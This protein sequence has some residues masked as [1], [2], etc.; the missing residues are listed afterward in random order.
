MADKGWKACPVI[1]V[2]AS[3]TKCVTDLYVLHVINTKI[4]HAKRQKVK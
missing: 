1:D 2:V 4:F 3:P